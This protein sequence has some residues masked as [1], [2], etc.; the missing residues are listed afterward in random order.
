[1]IEPDNG[2]IQFLASRH[3]GQLPFH[4]LNPRLQLAKIEVVHMCRARHRR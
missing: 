2:L 3:A 1:M 4:L